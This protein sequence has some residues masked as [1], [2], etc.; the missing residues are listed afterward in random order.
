MK[1]ALNKDYL[2][3]RNIEVRMA[4]RRKGMMAT[5]ERY[6]SVEFVYL[7]LGNALSG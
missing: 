1:N 7:Q 6:S 2:R 5:Y 3:C 4:E